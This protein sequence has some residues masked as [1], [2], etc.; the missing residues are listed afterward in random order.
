MDKFFK[1]WTWQHGIVVALIVLVALK[2][3]NDIVGALPMAVAKQ[4]A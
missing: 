1:G 4:V 2:F 3:K